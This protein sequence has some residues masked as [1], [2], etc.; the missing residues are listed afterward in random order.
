MARM[1]DIKVEEFFKSYLAH[2]SHIQHARGGREKY[3]FDIKIRERVEIPDRV[4]EELS[5]KELQEWFDGEAEGRLRDYAE[6]LKR[7]YPWIENWFVAGRSGGW[8]VISTTDPVAD[9]W[10]MRRVRKRLEDLQ[11]IEER[12]EQ[13]MDRFIRDMESED[14]WVGAGAVGPDYTKSVKHWRPE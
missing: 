6:W 13:A 2:P 4:R 9:E 12:L 7:I 10:N 5:S 14:W 3:E 8:L 1:T 11:G